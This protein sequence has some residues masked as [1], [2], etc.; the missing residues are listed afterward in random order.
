MLRH[1]LEKVKKGERWHLIC[2][3][4]KLYLL[5]QLIVSHANVVKPQFTTEMCE[6]VAYSILDTSVEMELQSMLEG[7]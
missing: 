6:Q 3:E 4:L 5:Q 1:E 2:I 7:E